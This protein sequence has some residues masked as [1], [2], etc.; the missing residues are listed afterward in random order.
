M[1]ASSL[2]VSFLTAFPPMAASARSL[3]FFFRDSSV[4]PARME[5][6]VS[7]ACSLADLTLNFS[8]ASAT[9]VP[10]SAATASKSAWPAQ[11]RSAP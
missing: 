2:A 4:M 11:P 6:R 10:S 7:S 5:S 9:V 3:A 1:A 8:R